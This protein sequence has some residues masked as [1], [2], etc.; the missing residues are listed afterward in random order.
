[1]ALLSTI[2]FDATTLPQGY[3]LLLAVAILVLFEPYLSG[4]E[5]NQ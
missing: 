5:S 3:F 4:H 1:M 2:N